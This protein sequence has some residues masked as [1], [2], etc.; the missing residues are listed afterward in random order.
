M[1]VIHNTGG[2]QTAAENENRDAAIAQL[3]SMVDFLCILEDIP[4]DATEDSTQTEEGM[5]NE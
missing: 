1:K 5:S 2:I 4:T 3:A